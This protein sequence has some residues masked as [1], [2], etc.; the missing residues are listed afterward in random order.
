MRRALLSLLVLAGCGGG[1]EPVTVY[2][3]S[4]LREV[5]PEVA[6]DAKLDLGGSGALRL[7]I[8]R[9][10]PADAF[11]AASTKDAQA[12][13]DAGR[14]ERPVVFATNELVLVVPAQGARVRSVD[15]LAGRRVAIGADGVP[16]GDYTREALI[17]TGGMALDTA[18]VSLERD[19]ASITA[20]VALGSADAGFAY[21]TDVAASDGRLRAIALP[22]AA[23]PV[24]RYAACAVTLRGRDVVQRLTSESGRAALRRAGFGLP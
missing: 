15:D 10:A 4:S 13:A 22:A 16:V 20:K 3:A 8:E 9:G 12:L 18:T 1:E 19:V 6:S 2:G 23:R 7:R 5:L 24:V 21:R 14:C 17:R 11:A